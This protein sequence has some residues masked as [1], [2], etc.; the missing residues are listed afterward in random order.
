MPAAPVGIEYPAWIGGN[1]RDGQEMRWTILRRSAAHNPITPLGA[2]QYKVGRPGPG[3]TLGATGDVNRPC[4]TKAR[5]QLR[6]PAPIPPCVQ[7]SRPTTGRTRACLDPKQRVAGIDD[8][9]IA[10]RGL[11]NALPR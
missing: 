5:Q 3:T 1:L 8:Q 2:D 4:K 7:G 9:T 10:A 11:E 6:K